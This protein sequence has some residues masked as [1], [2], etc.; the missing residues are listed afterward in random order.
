MK[1]KA[2]VSKQVEFE[3]PEKW[4]LQLGAYGSS[5]MG[6]CGCLAAKEV[7]VVRAASAAGLPPAEQGFYNAVVEAMGGYK[8]YQDLV[9]SS[10]DNTLLN[11]SKAYKALIAATNEVYGTHIVYSDSEEGYK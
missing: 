9:V 4:E 3:F 6:R 1:V 8:E 11:R 2:E 7:A 10:A 5:E